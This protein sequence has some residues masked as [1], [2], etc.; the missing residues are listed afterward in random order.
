MTKRTLLV[1]V[2]GVV[3]VALGVGAA[4][5]SAA[6]HRSTPEAARTSTTAQH[7]ASQPVVLHFTSKTTKST[8]VDNDPKDFS[9]GDLLT[10]H[11]VWYQDG[12]KV[13]AMALTAAVTLRTSAQTGE[14]MFTAVAS[15]KDGQIVLTGRFDVVPGNQTFGAAVT[16]GTGTYRNARGHAVFEQTSGDSTNLT[17]YLAP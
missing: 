10:Q 3:A 13:G 5:L 12:K 2:V 4:M 9:A 11:S 7:T 17:L 8:Y 16:G 15:V 6:G 14:V 1:A